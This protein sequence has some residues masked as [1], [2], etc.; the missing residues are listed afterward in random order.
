M[1]KNIKLKFKGHRYQG[2]TV[3]LKQLAEEYGLSLSTLKSRLDRGWSIEDSLSIPVGTGCKRIRKPSVIPKL[4]AV[5]EKVRELRKPRK[6]KQRLCPTCG[7]EIKD[8]D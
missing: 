6:V 5:Y 3:T 1:K 4:E 7:Q 8:Y 2:R